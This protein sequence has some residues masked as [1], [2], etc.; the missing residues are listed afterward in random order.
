MLYQKHVLQCIRSMF[1]NEIRPQAF[2]DQHNYTGS[3]LPRFTSSSVL[4]L[5]D[6]IRKLSEMPTKLLTCSASDHGLH[7]RH[8]L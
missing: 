1:C 3:T 8:L 2:H 6:V 5:I 7:S 4:S